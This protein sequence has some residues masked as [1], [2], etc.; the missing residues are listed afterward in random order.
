VDAPLKVRIGIGL[1]TMTTAGTADRFAAIVDRCEALGFDSLWV[2]ERV[3]APAPDPMV[4]LAVAAGRTQRLKLG[5]SVLVLPGRNPVLLAKEMATLDVL[6]GG[7]F[8]PAV[9]LGAVDPPEQRA[10]GVRREER[11]RRHDEALALMRRCW[12]GE[13]V[14]HH[15]EFYSVDDVQVLPRPVQDGF[16]VWLGGIAPSELRR[17]GRV[18]DGW[19]PSFCSAADVAEGRPVIEAAAAEAGR[20]IDP[21][22][23]GALVSYC[24]GEIPPRVVELIHRRRPGVDPRSVIPTRAGL[25]AALRELVDAGASKFV[26]MPL[27]GDADPHAELGQLADELLPLE[28]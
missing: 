25:P 15:G 22:H 8:L 27:G 1:G 28:T 2:S 5:T 18:G 16:D 11:G 19:L 9:G 21:Q 24:D 12:T 3:G 26:V 20:S 10:F 7:R 23:H 17:V 13:V 14:S 6:S 4:A